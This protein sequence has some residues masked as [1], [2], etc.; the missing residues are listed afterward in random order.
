MKL[1]KRQ[2]KRVSLDAKPSLAKPAR[3]LV[4]DDDLSV[5]TS[6]EAILQGEGYEVFTA[7][8]GR[9]GLKLAKKL[10]LDAVI[11]GLQIPLLSGMELIGTMRQCKPRL[12]IILIAANGTAEIAIRATQ[13]GAYDYILKP[14]DVP[15]LLVSLDKAVTSYRMAS[16]PVKLGDDETEHEALVGESR[17]MQLVYKDIGRFANKP[18]TILILGE[19][20][21]G[22]E[23]VARALFQYSDRHEKPF[24]AVNC[25]AIPENLIESELFGH[26]KGAFTGADMRRIGR[27]E[28]AD[29]GTLFLDEI[30]DLQPQTQVK[31]LR[32]LQEKCIQRV[33]SKRTIPVNVRVIAA[34]HIN[35]E[36]AIAEKRFREDLYYRLNGV[37]IDLPPLRDREDD[38]RQLIKFFI[39]RYTEELGL[40]ATGIKNAAI[41]F[42]KLQQWPG[43]VR[44][45]E[46]VI[47]NALL[48]CEGYVITVDK[49]ELICSGGRILSRPSS[50]EITAKGLGHSIDVLV[51]QILEEVKAGSR[52]NA[53]EPLVHLLEESLYKQ[54]IEMAGGNQ[55]KAARM[56]GV[57]RLTMREKL[58]KFGCHPGKE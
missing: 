18:V 54:A 44:Q 1:Q 36:K 24:I 4:V 53:L 49:L 30:G 41:K 15:V 37:I 23:L 22:K 43:N 26:E 3:V 29:G 25:A 8:D 10:K 47:R 14:Y 28:Q 19:T 50:A 38:I 48:E 34:T 58:Q 12:P 27:F 42:L 11:T 6:L 55:A 45:L 57:S 16:I 20:G 13:L 39:R 9:E 5:Q 17:A 40:Q 32:V 31:L 35:L 33:G 51:R 2:K 46:N 52:E 21:T 7:S 56:V